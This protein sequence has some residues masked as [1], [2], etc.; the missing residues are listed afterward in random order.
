MARASAEATPATRPAAAQTA[1]GRAATLLAAR[2]S[3]LPK[4]SVANA[5]QFVTLDKTALTE[6]VGRLPRAT[7]DLIVAGIDVVLGS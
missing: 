7:H 6:R 3:G 1:A 4:D 2:V 5:L